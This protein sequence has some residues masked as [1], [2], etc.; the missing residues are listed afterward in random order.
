MLG[1][2]SL[3]ES[4]TY[5]E[6]LQAIYSRGCNEDFMPFS[7]VELDFN[8][9][10]FSKINITQKEAESDCATKECLEYKLRP[11]NISELLGH[12]HNYKADTFYVDFDYQ[13]EVNT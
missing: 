5:Q 3:S 7:N 10:Y 11:T 2:E 8:W 12:F 4:S 6:C 13:K 9:Q 1:N